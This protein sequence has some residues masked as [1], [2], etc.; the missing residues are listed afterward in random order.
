MS[1]TDVLVAY[2][3]RH[4]GTEE[5]ASAVADELRACGLRVHVSEVRGVHDL[6]RYRAVVLGSTM[7]FGRWRPGAVRF[8][9]RHRGELARMRV[10]L[11]QTG[12]LGRRTRVATPGAVRR[13]LPRTRIRA[14]ARTISLELAADEGGGSRPAP[15]QRL[16]SQPRR[17]GR[18]PAP[19]D[20][21]R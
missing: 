10:W 13:F 9:R 6:P 8:L 4:G 1:G 15:G 11:F 18:V 16:G 2:A 5:I 19:A 21:D 3:G 14:W 12:P 17:V 20:L 7:C